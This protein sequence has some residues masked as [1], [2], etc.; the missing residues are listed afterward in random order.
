MV[1]LIA[2]KH[3]WMQRDSSKDWALTTMRLLI[4]LSNQQLFE[5]SYLLLSP[6]DGYFASWMFRMRFFMAF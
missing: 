5:W 4:L 3:G 2:I 6:A 1:Q